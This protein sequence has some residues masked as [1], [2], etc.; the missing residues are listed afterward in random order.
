VFGGPSRPLGH[1]HGQAVGE[2][3]VEGR[4]DGPHVRSRGIA[5]AFR[6]RFGRLEGERACGSRQ[7][8]EGV[9]F[10]RETE[11]AYARAQA[12][13]FVADEY[14]LRF[15]VPVNDGRFLLVGLP[16]TPADL[17]DQINRDLDGDE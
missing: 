8:G 2:Q 5:F 7:Q 13:G 3:Q 14:V 9:D 6:E 10:L 15:D 1:R 17:F 4:A 11:I 12:V 16:E